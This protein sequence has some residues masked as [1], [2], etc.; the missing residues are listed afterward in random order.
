ML[1][2]IK[3]ISLRDILGIFKF[4]IVLIPS[5][6]KRI[7][8]KLKKEELWIICETERTARDNGYAFYKYIKTNHKEIKCYYAINY[9]S[10]DYEKVNKLGDTVKWASL[11]HYYLYMSATNNLSS[12]KE[13]N[14]NQTL[15]TIL[16][17]YLNL[18]NNRIF[19]QHGITKDNLP[20]FHYKNSKF[21]Y[22]ICGAK[23]EYEYIIEKFGYNERN[24]AYTGFARFDNLYNNN[25]DDKMILFIPTWRRWLTSKEQ[26]VKSDYYKNLQAI[27]NDKNLEKLLK[28]YDK[29][30]YFYP[31][32]GMQPYMDD[33]KITNKRV[34]LYDISNSDIQNL[35]KTGRLL[36]T[37]YSSVYFDIAYMNKPVIYFQPDYKEYREKHMPE[38][39]F[40]Y[41]KDG[42]GKVCETTNELYSQLEYYLKNNYKIEKK[43][44]DRMNDFF[45]IKDNKNCERIYNL[46][47]KR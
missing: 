36:I 17:L 15:F 22:F 42:F 28:K 26:V 45:T 19:L 24:T 44:N 2:K 29:Y 5:L 31:H 47:I 11:K 13:G 30:L 20:M 43:Y 7:I 25:V 39:Y 34:K 12:H 27:V 10:P 6:I 38:G 32:S 4:A 18:Y 16:H 41:K 8:L 21:K 40:D 23:R 3:K 46:L 33:F 35:L 9:S 14:P 1:N 37:D